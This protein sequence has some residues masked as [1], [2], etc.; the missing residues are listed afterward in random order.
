MFKYPLINLNVLGSITGGKFFKSFSSSTIR[1]SSYKLESLAKEHINS[2]LPTTHLIINKIL[3]NQGLSITKNK[4]EELLK[5]KGVEINLP[6]VNLE[7]KKLLKEFTGNSKYKGL[8]GVYVFINKNTGQKYVGSSNLLRRRMEYYFKGDFPLSGKFSPLL[9]KEGLKAFKLV[10]YKLA[11]NKF[12][13]SDALLLEQYFLLNKV[14]NLNTLKVVN[15]GSSKGINVYV[16]DLSCSTLY[17]HAKSQI[18]LKINLNLHPETCKKYLDSKFPYLNK[19]L[20]LSHPISTAL[21]NKNKDKRKKKKENRKKKKRQKTKEKRKQ[22]TEKRQ[23]K[24]ENRKK[25]KEKRKKKS[26]I[27]VKE[28]VSIMQKER[29]AIYTLGTRRNIP[30]ILEI[31]E[32]NTF[33][34]SSVIGHTLNFD[35]LT[36]CIEGLRKFGLTIKRDTLTKYIKNG[37]V[38]HNFLCKYTDKLKPIKFEE[39]GLIIDEYKKLKINS[40][41]LKVNKKNKPI[42]VKGDNFAK[43]L[44]SIKD[45]IS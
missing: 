32:G 14:F 18:D 13:S 38:F 39:V 44:K 6:V 31:L 22:K 36:S 20:L 42:L 34:D 37:K 29:Q 27:T 24:K 45:T 12:N 43:S 8:F 41:S 11:V 33:V 9:H 15:T 2:N 40:D 4:L 30:V 21:K 19:L 3:F 10:I 28:L 7:D 26:H 16:Y 5:V 17:Y 23:K 25:T 35:S 1:D